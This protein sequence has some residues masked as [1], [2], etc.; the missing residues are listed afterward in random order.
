MSSLLSNGFS[1]IRSLAFRGVLLY[2]SLS[3][4]EGFT[5]H[6]DQTG[7]NI[8]FSRDS[9]EALARNQGEFALPSSKAP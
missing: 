8:V 2:H 3:F 4:F 7:K 9:N 1:S 6:C 5:A